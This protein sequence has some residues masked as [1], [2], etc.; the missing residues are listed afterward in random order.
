[1]HQVNFDFLQIAALP[2]ITG[3]LH[4]WDIEQTEVILQKLDDDYNKQKE[5]EN[6]HNKL[7]KER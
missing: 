3:L 4:G 7:E 1:M 5:E 2:E 6:K